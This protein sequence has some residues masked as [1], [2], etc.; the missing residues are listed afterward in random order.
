MLL[1]LPLF[2]YKEDDFIS[3]N[4]SKKF[5]FLWE[6]K[7]MDVVTIGETMVLLTP[8][9]NG[10]MRYA[11]Q[12]NRSFG[13]AES[14][15]CIGLTRLGHQ[16]GWI[17]RVGDDEFGRAMLSFIRGE[18]VDVSQV[19]VD[20]IAQ[21]GVFFKEIKTEQDISVYYY[22]KDSA[23]S[24]M[25]AEMINENYLKQAKYLHVSGIT[26]AIS[27]SCYEAV[28]RAIDIAKKHGVK[29]VFDPNLRR[30][31]WSEER[32]REV[33]I[34]LCTKADIVLP[35]V[36]EAEFMFGKMDLEKLGEKILS[37]GPKLVVI[38]VGEKGAYYFNS[39]KCEHVPGFLVRQ[40]VDPC[41]ARDGFAA[42]F[43]SGLLDGLS[44]EDSVSRGCAVGAIATMYRGDVEGLPTKKEINKFTSHSNEDVVR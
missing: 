30:K 32:A 37:L 23:A 27:E 8:T 34:D 21:T 35:G 5:I 20:E 10:P 4:A 42:G 13:G 17:S 31:L 40:V 26:P 2:F 16:V 11:S 9:S 12:F 3:Y 15:F 44:T 38:K 33:L 25:T 29:I 14:N 19:T 22:R 28:Q 7:K 6:L 18:G 1:V 39:E 24:K 43:V 36:L 41:G